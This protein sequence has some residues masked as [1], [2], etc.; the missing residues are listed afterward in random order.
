MHP[1][2]IFLS[3]LG[4]LLLLLQSP[5]PAATRVSA[6]EDWLNHYY[7]NPQ[8]ERFVPAI[9]ELS[10]TGFFERP[11][12]VPLAIGF[13]A[14]LFAQNPELIDQWVV[15]CS[16]LPRAHQRLMASALWYSGS[17]KG[18][19]YLRAYS[20][21]VGPE[22]RPDIEQLLASKP[23]LRERASYFPAN[24]EPLLASK[25]LKIL[26][27]DMEGLL[28][29]ISVFVSNGHTSGQQIVKV[30]DGKKTILY[31]GDVI[32]TS[33]HVRLAWVMGYDLRPLDLIEEKQKFLGQAAKDGWY[34]FFEHD[35]YCDMATI[36]RNGTDF[37][38]LERFE[39]N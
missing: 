26:N 39:L 35:P 13:I 25:K 8:P 9:Y 16:G 22:L 31:C 29:G 23:N 27:G 19:D 32:P 14:S 33:S 3:G 21:V 30:S 24:I 4:A 36:Q 1:K 18:A 38:V 37:Q 10:R 2:K 5:A 20:R 11:G 6:S 17:V 12:H 28:P 15:L 34:L 7:E